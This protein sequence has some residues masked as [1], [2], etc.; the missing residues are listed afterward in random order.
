MCK[1]IYKQ[2]YK[3][4]TYKR[5]FSILVIKKFTNLC[6]QPTFRSN[7]LQVFCKKDVL[8]N[9]TK[10]TGKHLC[11]RWHR[12]FPVNFVKF[13]RTPFL[14]E[15]LRW[16][17][18]NLEKVIKTCKN[19]LEIASCVNDSC[20]FGSVVITFIAVFWISTACYCYESKIFDLRVLMW[21]AQYYQLLET[22]FKNFKKFIGKHL[23]WSLFLITLRPHADKNLVNDV[24]F[25]EFTTDGI[26]IFKNYM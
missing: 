8:R 19:S 24:S 7:C 25:L 26:L 18:L 6:F 2:I 4:L 14:T 20:A 17:F 21:K 3:R 16:L 15:H 9:F 23:Y 10:F 11:Q 5:G 12:C 1:L 13:L 22:V